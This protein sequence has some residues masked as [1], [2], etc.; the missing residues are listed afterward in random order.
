VATFSFGASS[1]VPTLIQWSADGKSILYTVN[2][3][4]VSNVWSQPLAGGDPKQITFF[5][6]G[7]MTGFAWS[8]DGKMFAATRGSLLRDAVLITD[9]R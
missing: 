2:R 7:L 5:R 8:S 6:D 1:T 4:S 3:E 9:L